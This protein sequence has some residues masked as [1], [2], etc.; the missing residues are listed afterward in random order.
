M[1]R[2]RIE[3][4]L[5]EA[6]RLRDPS[7]GVVERRGPESEAMD[8]AVDLPLDE[9]RIFENAKVLRDRRSR[10]RIRLGELPDRRLPIARELRKNA[11]AG[12]VCERVKD[13]IELRGTVNHLVNRMAA[14]HTCQRRAVIRARFR[15]EPTDA[16]QF[17]ASF[18]SSAWNWGV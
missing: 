2:Q 13:A 15:S 11:A 14:R 7:G 9:P 8:P 6:S 1:P 5:P 17:A 4:R 12:T 18:V 3:S 10:N 16:N